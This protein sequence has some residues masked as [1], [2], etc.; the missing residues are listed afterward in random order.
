M[1]VAT[2]TLHSLYIP[3]EIGIYI[4]VYDAVSSTDEKIG[5]EHFFL[6]RTTELLYE[7]LKKLD[8]VDIRATL[9]HKRL[10]KDTYIERFEPGMSRARWKSSSTV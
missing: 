8:V 3:G 9:E 6:M 5:L 4:T 2:Y 10:F 7:E 1:L